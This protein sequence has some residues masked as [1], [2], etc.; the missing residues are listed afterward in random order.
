MA[1]SLRPLQLL[2]QRRTSIF[3][4]IPE[5]LTTST[6][7]ST[8]QDDQSKTDHL[9]TKYG[10]RLSFENGQIIAVR[11]VSPSPELAIGFSTL[12]SQ[13][14]DSP[15]S[16]VDNSFPSPHELSES[17]YSYWLLPD[18]GTSRFLI[19]RLLPARRGRWRAC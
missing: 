16:P 4:L 18:W 17:R 13:T 7:S 11:L 3:K 15:T 12:G 9:D 1:L 5:F 8:A 6:K 14:T 2:C 10:L 19:Q